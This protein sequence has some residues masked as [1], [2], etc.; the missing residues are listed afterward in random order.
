MLTNVVVVAKS[1]SGLA[2]YSIPVLA[3]GANGLFISKVDGLGPVPSNV[4]TQN[5]GIGDGEYYAGSHRGKRDIVLSI[6]MGSRSI[7]V[8]AARVELYGRFYRDNESL[9]LRLEFDNRSSVEIIGYL[10]T[11]ESDRFVQDPESQI[12]I[13]CPKPNFL[14]TILRTFTGASGVSPAWTDVLYSGNRSV[15]FLTQILLPTPA[16]IEIGTL[17]VQTGLESSPGVFSTSRTLEIF[18]G[19]YFDPVVAGEQLWIDTRL[20]LKSVYIYNPT[21]QTRRNALKKMTV[22]S[23]WPILHPGIN[24]FRVVT[25]TVTRNWIVTFYNEFGGV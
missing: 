8:D 17:I 19:G 21:N 4:I 12:S 15:G 6:G 1:G 25:P 22:E 2:D 16:D 13:I 20:G 24:K 11:N 10:E 14:E 18:V 7:D 5:Y 23:T 3:P 9:K